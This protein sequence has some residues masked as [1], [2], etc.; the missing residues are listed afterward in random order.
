ME[1]IEKF[2]FSWVYLSKQ[3]LE[4]V[5]SHLNTFKERR[6]AVLLFINEINVRNYIKQ[7]AKLVLYDESLSLVFF[8]LFLDY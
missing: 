6:E 2:N 7:C 5:S 3:L 1:D 4:V 8:V